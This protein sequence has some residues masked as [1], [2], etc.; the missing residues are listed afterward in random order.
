M[1]QSISGFP[2]VSDGEESPCN[3]GDLG[4]IPGSGRSPGGGHGNP[5]QHSCLENPHGWKSLVGCSPWGCKEADLGVVCACVYVFLD[6][7]S[8]FEIKSGN[9]GFDE[10]KLKLLQFC[11]VLESFCV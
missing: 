6:L 5:L 11:Y 2:G 8:G 1:V 3:A 9:V 7:K 4:L 10:Q